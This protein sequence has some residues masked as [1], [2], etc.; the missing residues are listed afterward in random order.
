MIREI[1]RGASGKLSQNAVITHFGLG[2]ATKIDKITVYWIGGNTQTITNV[3]AN[4]L[5][6]ITEIPTPKKAVF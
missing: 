4:Q 6:T 1:D 5:L 2:S 3:N